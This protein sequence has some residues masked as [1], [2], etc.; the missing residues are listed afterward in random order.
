MAPVRH[1][2][3][4]TQLVDVVLAVPAQS[5]GGQQCLQV[6]ACLCQLVAAGRL[7]PWVTLSFAQLCRSQWQLGLACHL[8]PYLASPQE[9]I[10][11]HCGGLPATADT[12][13]L[14]CSS[15]EQERRLYNFCAPHEVGAVAA[16]QGQHHQPEFGTPL[17]R[18]GWLLWWGRISGAWGLWVLAQATPLPQCT[19][20][21]G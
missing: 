19:E 20:E 15:F 18:S 13:A 16:K 2:S 9:Q 14:G 10:Q 6:L 5:Y 8:T 11:R 3:D 7:H 4:H 21:N 17:E 1:Q 12:K